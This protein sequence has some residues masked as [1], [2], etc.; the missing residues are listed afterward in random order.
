MQ[1]KQLECSNCD[2]L[3]G[4]AWEVST[5]EE[6]T[7]KYCGQPIHEILDT[8]LKYLIKFLDTTDNLS[9]QV[10]PDNDYASKYENSTG[11][12]ECW[13]IL[14]SDEN[15]GIYL[16]LK[17]GV[18]KEEFQNAIESKEDLSNY[19]NFIPVKKGD[20][21]FVPA[22]SLHA[23]GSGILLC[24]VQQSSGI[25]YRAWDWNRVDSDGEGRD[26]HITQA[27][28]VTEFS[29]DKNQMGYFRYTNFIESAQNIATLIEHPDF[30]TTL[31][32]SDSEV[33]V[34]FKSS[35]KRAKAIVLFEG[36][37]TLK[38]AKEEETVNSYHSILLPHDDACLTIKPE[39]KSLFILV[40]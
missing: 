3:I 6:G 18:I 40:E 29:S 2:T 11:K 25:T 37:L 28:E 13:L 15:S 26:L 33:K 1:K 12:T 21:F 10:H 39:E 19:M 34:E 36:K 5:L 32:N 14:E 16:G 8:P 23:I 22:G 4:E 24:E 7:S 27:L 35:S 20:F 31:Y 38:R 9:V 30:K 17:E